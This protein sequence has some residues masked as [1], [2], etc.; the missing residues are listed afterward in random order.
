M[1]HWDSAQFIFEKKGEYPHDVEIVTN[2]EEGK[3]PT[4]FYASFAVLH[5]ASGFWRDRFKATAWGPASVEKVDCSGPAMRYLLYE[6]YHF[7]LRG[8]VPTASHWSVPFEAYAEA[9]SMA[10]GHWQCNELVEKVF[11]PN[12]ELSAQEWCSS[13]MLYH[14]QCLDRFGLA[15]YMPAVRELFL[16]A[17]A[18]KPSATQ[19]CIHGDDEFSPEKEA[20][21]VA[22]AAEV[23]DALVRD[24][25]AKTRHIRRLALML[26]SSIHLAQ[27]YAVAILATLDR[28]QWD[29]ASAAN[30]EK[31]YLCSEACECRKIGSDMG[32]NVCDFSEVTEAYT[33]R[34]KVVDLRL[35]HSPT[36][37]YSITPAYNFKAFP[38]SPS[39]DRSARQV[40]MNMLREHANA[41]LLTQYRILKNVED[42]YG[43]QAGTSLRISMAELALGI[44]T[45]EKDKPAP[46]PEPAKATK[47]VAKRAKPNA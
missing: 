26:A 43:K 10:K 32:S 4:I 29:L 45:V 13:E 20:V 12:L 9:F 31:D 42:V 47:Q 17:C 11:A 8:S 25:A 39:M 1:V 19:A 27:P 5:R 41:N 18:T 40:R 35:P 23:V 7:Y 38:R 6:I 36:G 24:H 28:R 2:A 22:T 34:P 21:S 3:A 44:C 46:A 16:E 30:F 37:I 14:S 15:E 33:V